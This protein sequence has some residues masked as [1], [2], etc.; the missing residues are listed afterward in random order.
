MWAYNSV[1]YQIYP[2]GFCDAPRENDG[3][4]VNRIGRLG[5]WAEHIRKVGADAVYLSP[6][7]ESDRRHPRLPENRLP[8][9]YKRRFCRRLQNAP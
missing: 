2:I 3:I 5:S 9:R 1:F 8:A 4:T 7:F 6:I